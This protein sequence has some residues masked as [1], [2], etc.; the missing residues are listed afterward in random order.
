MLKCKCYIS[1]NLNF[2]VLFFQKSWRSHI[3]LF[4]I[5]I[6]SSKLHTA[7]NRRWSSLFV[8]KHNKYTTKLKNN[9]LVFKRKNIKRHDVNIFVWQLCL[10]EDPIKKCTQPFVSV[11]F[12]GIHCTINL[13][14]LCLR[15]PTLNLCLSFVSALQS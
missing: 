7:D 11:R 12:N 5:Y 14:I 8:F 3:L 1:K 15:F 2:F 4:Y 13:Y 9:K 6:L 10:G